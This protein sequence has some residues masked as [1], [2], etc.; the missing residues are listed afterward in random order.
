MKRLVYIFST[1]FLLLMITNPAFAKVNHTQAEAVAWITQ[2]AKTG[3]VMGGTGQCVGVAKAYYSYLGQG[4]YAKGNGKDYINNLPPGWTP[5]IGNKNL[6]PGDIAVEFNGSKNHVF[7]ITQ[8]SGNYNYGVHQNYAGMQYPTIQRY[9]NSRIDGVVRPDWNSAKPDTTKPVVS[10]VKVSNI[11]SSGYDV[12][13]TATDNV[14]V[15]KVLFPTWTTASHDDELWGQGTKN[16]NTWTYH[17]NVKDH[18]NRTG[19]YYT[20]VYAYDAAGNYGFGAPSTKITVPSPDTTGP[21]ITN[22]K[23]SNI[24]NTGFKVSSTVTDS[25]G[26]REVQYAVWVV[27]NKDATEKWIKATASGNTYSANVNISQFGNRTGTYEV[28][29]YAWDKNGNRSGPVGL[30]VTVPTK[31]NNTSTSA[32]PIMKNFKVTN[33]TTTSFT[34]QSQVTSSKGINKVTYGIQLGN[35]E[36]SYRA[37]LKSGNIYTATIPLSDFSYTSGT[38]KI[39]ALILDN[40]GK[41]FEVENPLSI[42]I[43]AKKPTTSTS[44]SPAYFK[45]SSLTLKAGTTSSL[46]VYTTSEVKNV[47]SVTWSS[48]NN[49]V[50]TISKGKVTAI[51]KGTATVSATLKTST[52]K[53][54][55][56]SCKVTVN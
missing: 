24:T 11:T 29:V 23:S 46:V 6:Q 28:H 44:S 41:S 8:V 12:S 10:N 53:T 52:G 27:G 45:V 3:A 34:V 15:T 38:Y 39:Y 54:Y 40:T 50:A 47:T 7:V 43:T 49:K 14:G 30:K 2:Q 55:K 20:H 16:G 37:T 31:Q 32:V 48:T 42:S 22:M 36:K 56:A 5:I 33:K 1:L 25:S 9:E 26:I 17:V 4:G 21:T 13:C 19:V 18:K 51:S 35:R